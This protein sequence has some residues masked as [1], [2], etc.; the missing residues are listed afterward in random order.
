MW[1]KG[2]ENMPDMTPTDGPTAN[3]NAAAIASLRR[4][5]TR[6]LRLFYFFVLLIPG[7]CIGPFALFA[8]FKEGTV[9]TILMVCGLLLPFV[10]LGGMLLMLGDRSRYKRS[11][12]M[13]EQAEQLGLRFIESPQP[14][15]FEYLR[16]SQFFR[17]AANDAAMNLMTG[18]IEGIPLT[19]LDYSVAYGVGKYKIVSDQTVAFLHDAAEGL[20]SFVLYPKSW[21]DTLSEML[22]ERSI[23]L[24]GQA[25]FNQ[26]FILRT[27]D[28]EAVTRLFTSR[29]V[30]LALSDSTRSVEVYEELL[31][32]F[33]YKKREKPQ[34]IPQLVEEAMSWVKA[35]RAAGEGRA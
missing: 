14:K 25:A 30:E 16:A 15:D 19:A 4:R 21:L 26:R 6:V 3:D 28:K 22:K 31:A 33:R 11:L 1:M 5:A 8:L 35:L 32:V 12:A 27:R 2:E 23:E 7:G 18:K 34:E 17:G 24:P 13:A 29:I 20:P 10:G 9:A